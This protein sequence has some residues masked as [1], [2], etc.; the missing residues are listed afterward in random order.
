LKFASLLILIN[1]T[2]L[3]LS[4]IYISYY[5]GWLAGIVPY[6]LLQVVSFSLSRL[7][8]FKS[9]TT[10]FFFWTMMISCVV[11]YLLSY[12]DI[13][14]PSIVSQPMVLDQLQIIKELPLDLLHIFK[15][16]VLGA[17]NSLKNWI[18]Q[19]IH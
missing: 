15:E 11:A 16:L 7:F 17:F 5:D 8:N 2:G 4:A 12:M 10:M 13:T 19:L 18:T 14:N 3:I 6:F 1:I 9:I